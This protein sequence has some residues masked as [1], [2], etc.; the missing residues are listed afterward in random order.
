MSNCCVVSVPPDSSFKAFALPVH[1]WRA[2]L[3]AGLNRSITASD[4]TLGHI[5]EEIAQKTRELERALAQ[6]AAQK[7]AEQAPPTCPIC[8][9]KL[10]RLTHGHERTVQT[11]FG[12]IGVQRA[13]GWCRRCK[14]WRFP[15]DHALGIAEPGSASP[16]V[17]EMAALGGSKMPLT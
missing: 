6:E 4:H 3:T 7:K 17:Q 9:A 16:S 1:D 11:R 8:G 15:A 13:R 12:P 5:E 2:R 14:Q 10:T